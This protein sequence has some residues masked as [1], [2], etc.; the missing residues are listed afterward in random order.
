MVVEPAKPA[1]PNPPAP[2]EIGVG[3]TLSAPVKDVVIH[4]DEISCTTD[5]RGIAWCFPGVTAGDHFVK[6][7]LPDAFEPDPGSR[8]ALVEG[9]QSCGGW[10]NCELKITAKRK[11]QAKAFPGRIS[12]RDRAFRT[13]DGKPWTWAFMTE[14]LLLNDLL[15]GKDISPILDEVTALGANGVR[16]VGM[17]HWIPLN[18]RGQRDFTPANYGGQYLTGLGQLA[19]LLKDR[20]LYLEFTALADAQ[21][22]MPDPQ[23]QRAFLQQVAAVLSFKDNVFL[24]HCNEPFKNGCE[25]EL[26]MG[27][28]PY[29]V[30][31]ASGAYDVQETPTKWTL[32][33]VFDY[34][35]SHPPRDDEW[36]RKAHDAMDIRDGFGSNGKDFAG[37]QVPVVLD[38]PIGAADVAVGG[39]RANDPNLFR[40]FGAGCALF[41]AGCTFHSNAGVATKPLSDIQAAAAR[42]FFAGI[43]AVSSDA[44]LWRYNRGGLG[45]MPITHSDDLALRTFAKLSGNTA[46]VAVIA[47]QP[48]WRL[49]EDN[50]YHCT[51][52]VPEG[53]VLRCER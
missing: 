9:A 51:A 35:T 32:D 4:I 43:N 30:L 42:G 21:L 14:F 33:P 27:R 26:Q 50:G 7:D 2:M 44:Q 10:P 11:I 47:R 18:E 38:E 52:L 40:E 1:L 5:D 19:D 12:A 48:A 29:V 36:A 16:V 49:V 46:Y 31:Q 17:A 28:L 20:G 34:V 25:R 15:D 45:G 22:L 8:Y 24:E 6:A 3:I 13:P 23:T 53:D 41:G 39:R 37:V